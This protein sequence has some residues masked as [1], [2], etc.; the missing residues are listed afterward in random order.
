MV[1]GAASGLGAA[2][3]DRLARAG[4][5]LILVG[6]CRRRVA[7]VARRIADET[8]RNVDILVADLS[9]ATDI[10]TVELAFWTNPRMTTL[11]NFPDIGATPRQSGDEAGGMDP[12]MTTSLD[13]PMRL[14]FSALRAMALGGGTIIN[15]AT[16]LAVGPPDHNGLPN[17]SKGFTL[18]LSRTL[19]LS[20]LSAS[21]HVQAVLPGDTA[22]ALW[23]LAGA[24]LEH[25]V[26]SDVRLI[27]EMVDAALAAG[28][29]CEV[30]TIASLPELADLQPGRPA[31]GMRLRLAQ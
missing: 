9:V 25:L 23:G 20:P 29:A 1:T 27:E 24:P 2:Y 30:V 4:H 7:A 22:T 18:A 14:A 5:D 12:L 17:G 15:V 8:G 21:V 19:R 10:T 26:A 6:A 13:A 3:A 11:V 16:T 28:A 31:Q